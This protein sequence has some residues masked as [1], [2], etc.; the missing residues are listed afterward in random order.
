MPQIIRIHAEA[1]LKPAWGSASN[2][3]GVCCLVEPCP[4]GMLVS[5]RRKGRCDALV[6]SDASA[7]Y[8]CG[9][10]TAPE[11]FVRPAWLARGVGRVAARLIAAGLGCDSDL[12][13]EDE[14]SPVS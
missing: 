7:R 6:W 3:C 9:L 8:H 13:L 2:G 14:R 12:A 11:T 1:P 4:V 5:R 10:L